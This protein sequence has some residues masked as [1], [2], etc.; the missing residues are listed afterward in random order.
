MSCDGG[1]KTIRLG[2]TD[3]EVSRVGM[4]GIPIQRPPLEEAVKV[5]RRALDLGVNLIDTS[6]GYGDSEVRIGK[7]IAGRRGE[8]VLATKGSWQ[9]KATTEEH[10]DRSLK[11]LN[12]GHIDLW[13]F[14]NPGNHEAAR[15]GRGV[16]DVRDAAVPFQPRAEG[17]GGEA[18][19]V[20]G[21]A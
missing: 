16:W 10:I 8:V 17:G 12:T 20:C 21:G 4:G 7:R 14:H 6:I 11:R 3:L 19:I 15:A 5:I 2:K 9:D 1:V 18:D 13:Q